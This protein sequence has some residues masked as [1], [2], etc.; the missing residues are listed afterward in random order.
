MW[1]TIQRGWDVVSNT[2]SGFY[3]DSVLETVY[4]GTQSFLGKIQAEADT[5]LGKF[6][7]WGYNEFMGNRDQARKNLP[8]AQRVSRPGGSSGQALKGAGASDMGVT[9]TA[10][11]GAASAMNARPGSP[12]AITIQRLQSKS[13]RGP[14]MG[15]TQSQISVKPRAK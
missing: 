12:I 13:A 4:E 10:A 9:P 8:K 15:L 14:I 1:E 11:K 7:T 2:V 6:A 3:Q 5:P